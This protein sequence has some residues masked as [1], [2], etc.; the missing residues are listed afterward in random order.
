MLWLNEGPGHPRC[1]LSPPGHALAGWEV[2]DLNSVALSV[3]GACTPGP[4]VKT[5]QEGKARISHQHSPATPM[6]PQPLSTRGPAGTTHV[7]A[8]G[9][10]LPQDGC[11]L[12]ADPRG[13]A[14]EAGYRQTPAAG[15][16]WCVLLHV[17]A[18][19]SPE[20]GPLGETVYL[21]T[22]HVFAKTTMLKDVSASSVRGGRGA[23]PRRAPL[24][25]APSPKTLPHG[26]AFRSGLP[27]GAS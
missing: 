9:F 5:P 14:G 1:P 21:P 20:E 16:P 23:P 3:P 26:D 24:P 25:P 27:I 10:L 6:L 8:V 11:G 22:C 12:P 19:H 2:G 18:P 13:A 15:V 4:I 17:L 7:C